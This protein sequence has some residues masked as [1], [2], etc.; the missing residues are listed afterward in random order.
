MYSPNTI[1]KLNQVA[2]EYVPIFHASIT[3]AIHKN[4]GAGAGSVK[5]DIIPGDATKSPQVVVTIN[6][7]V[8]YLDRRKLQWT[9]LPNLRE[10]QAWAETK[11]SD[12]KAIKRLTWGTAWDK[13][14][15]DTWKPKPWRKKGLGAVLREMNR[16]LLEAFD[17]ALNED[18]QEAINRA[19]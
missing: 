19:K 7:H 2:R 12:P 1:E 10:L 16:R 6:D 15:N 4:T 17:A 18:L 14:R 11:T 9:K 8:L 13:R 3:A 5:V